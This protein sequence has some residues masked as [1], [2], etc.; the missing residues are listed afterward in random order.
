MKVVN[1]GHNGVIL[2]EY[3]GKKYCFYK[4][5]PVEINQA[6]YNDIVLSGHV[7]AQDVVLYEEPKVVEKPKET[8]VEKAKSVLKPKGKKKDGHK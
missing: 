4:D 1:R 8:I 2:T 7:S 6:V 5:I 3:N